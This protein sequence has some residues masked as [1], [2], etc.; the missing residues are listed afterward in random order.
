[1]R[2]D[3]FI[4]CYS[5]TCYHTTAFLLKDSRN[6]VQSDVKKLNSAAKRL[7]LSMFGIDDTWVVGIYLLFMWKAEPNDC[8]L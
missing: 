1:M 2:S 5:A 7:I 8:G 6:V 4:A 3:I